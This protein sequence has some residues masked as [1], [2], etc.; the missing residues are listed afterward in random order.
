[1]KALGGL[2]IL[3]N[4]AAIGRAARLEEVD[5]EEWNRTIGINLGGVYRTT[6]TA[7][8]HLLER[9][10]GNVVNVASISA[11]RGQAYNSLYCASKAGMLN[12]TRS[13]ALE[14]TSRGLRANCVCPSG[15]RTPLIR[16]FQPREDFEKQLLAYYS[17]PIEKRMAEPED[18]AKA[19]AFLAS[20]D[21]RMVN[22]AAFVIDGGTLA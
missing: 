13:I 5:E 8:P 16:N 3:V 17:P 12:F 19:I 21:A 2:D 15:I 10:G 20:E 1:V 6:R 14:F 4:V 11:M 7:I 9:P 22:G 18:I